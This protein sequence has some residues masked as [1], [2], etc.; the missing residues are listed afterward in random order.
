MPVDTSD[1]IGLDEYYNDSEEE[2][3]EE[4]VDE[5][6]DE[7]NHA[8]IEENNQRQ[9]EAAPR[10]NVEPSD[11]SDNFIHNDNDKEERGEDAVNNRVQQNRVEPLGVRAQ[12]KA[13]HK[14]YQRDYFQ[15]HTMIML[16][17]HNVEWLEQ[18]GAMTPNL[19]DTI[20]NATTRDINNIAR[21]RGQGISFPKKMGEDLVVPELIGCITLGIDWLDV[22]GIQMLL[23]LTR[24]NEDVIYDSLLEEGRERMTILNIEREQGVAGS[25]MYRS[26]QLLVLFHTL[27]KLLESMNVVTLHPADAN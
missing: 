8:T 5:A 20:I 11:E 1:D 17:D 18:H 7:I 2:E 21:S 24:G 27:H 19:R 12:R 9:A 6:V 3:Y 22:Y 15:K 23:T 10:R 16:E 4:E 14:T 13:L 26:G 25:A